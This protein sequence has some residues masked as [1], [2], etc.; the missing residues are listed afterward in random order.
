LSLIGK[1]VQNRRGPAAVIGDESQKNHCPTG[2]E[3]LVSR[4]T[5]EPENLPDD[6]SLYATSRTKSGRL[7]R[8]DTN[9]LRIFKPYAFS[10]SVGL[11]L[12]RRVVVAS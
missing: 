10:R 8:I 12:Y 3:G 6:L 7:E 9:C 5:R 4:E 11:F 2:W 1:T